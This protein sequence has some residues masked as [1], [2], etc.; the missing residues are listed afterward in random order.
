MN[1]LPELSNVS[2]DLMA[3][4]QETW[5]HT[6]VSRWFSQLQIEN[7]WYKPPFIYRAGDFPFPWPEATCC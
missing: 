4:V 5:F 3:L 7:L 6:M 2:R 1:F